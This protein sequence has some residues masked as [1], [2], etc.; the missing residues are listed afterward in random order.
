MTA[1]CPRASSTAGLRSRQ[2][3]GCATGSR[4]CYACPI[5][6]SSCILACDALYATSPGRRVA[7]SVPGLSPPSQH[8]HAL[9]LLGRVHCDCGEFPEAMRVLRR[10]IQLEPTRPD[11]MR[12]LAIVSQACGD[13]QAYMEVSA[14]RDYHR[15]CE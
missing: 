1:P 2:T 13:F 8:Y 5:A 3:P 7:Q 4:A 9:L 15:R 10:A 6:Y 14:V 11:A 12:G